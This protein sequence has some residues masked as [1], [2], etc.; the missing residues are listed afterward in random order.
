[1]R[2]VENFT[3]DAKLLRELGERLVGRPH[4]ALAELIKN[5]FDADARCVEITFADDR[6]E[7]VDDGHGMSHRIFVDR[8]MRIGTTHK[9][10]DRV[11]PELER[12]LTGSKGVGR[13]AAQLLAR[14]LTI[15]SVALKNPELEGMTRRRNARRNQ[16]H[17][18]IDA[19]I[20]WDDA[21]KNDDLTSIQIDIGI[22]DPSA[23]F[24]GGSTVGTRLVLDDLTTDWD[25]ERFR[26][27]AR[28]IWSLQPPFDVEDDDEV[29]FQVVLVSDQDDVE[30]VFEDQ[31]RAVLDIWSARITGALREDDGSKVTFEFGMAQRPLK[32]RKTT[33]KLAAADIPQ[34][35]PDR[36]LDVTVEMADRTKTFSVRVPGSAIHELTYEIRIFDLNNRQPKGVK[37]ETAR[38]YLR[39]FGGVH[40]YDSDFRL[41]YYGPDE[42]WLG[43]EAFHAHRRSAL[44]LLPASM[45]VEDAG[46]D[47]PTNHR[48]YGLTRISTGAEGMHAGE[49]GLAATDTLTIQVTRDRLVDNDAFAL[50]RKL[51]KVGM[52]IYTLERARRRAAETSTRKSGSSRGSN[53]SGAYAE[54]LGIIRDNRDALPAATYK[55][56]EKV[57]VGAIN[58]TNSLAQSARAHSA[59]LGALATAGMSALAYE[60]E[61]SK[62][63][64][65]I[66]RAS[67]RMAKLAKTLDGP[68]AEQVA[69]LSKELKDW[70]LRTDRLRGLFSP[71]LDES[72]RTEVVAYPA[73]QLL[74]DVCDNAEVLAR[75]TKVTVA[76][77][78]EPLD[79]PPASYAAWTSVF[80]NLVINAFNATLSTPVRCVDI[81]L[82]RDHR[83]GWVLV[84]DTGV[85]VDME[86]AERFFEPFERDSPAD[87]EAAALGLGGSGL[88]LTIVQMISEEVGAEVQFVEPDADHSTAVKVSWRV[89]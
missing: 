58:D 75:G 52:E 21:I 82:G 18:Q 49:H 1:M 65:R 63:R 13:L 67:S 66:S 33:S 85:G 2:K 87:P 71:L 55:H 74:Q 42:D 41:P 28:E 20:D 34:K 6:I 44:P 81:S 53:P 86:D 64:N 4:I 9:E 77:F 3:V 80:Q 16:V 45:Q 54:V 59:L 40:I 25:A 48:I 10:A 31:M 37:V 62:Q 23:R 57:L 84:Q 69:A 56:V 30:D 22:N 50:L 26:R 60:H 73:S 51:V 70:T 32:R 17:P 11:S 35:L 72:D 68:Q 89:A 36:I 78:D 79:L 24:A 19:T 47:M 29:G 15:Q 88:G 46:Q 5:A 27:L 7:V 43:I 8:W 38:Q 83:S 61:S 39:D 14:S 12:N 76:S